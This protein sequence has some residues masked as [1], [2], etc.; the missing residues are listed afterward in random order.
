M[1]AEGSV[2]MIVNE[3]RKRKSDFE[4]R[5]FNYFVFSQ[6]WNRVQILPLNERDFI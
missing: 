3:I 5:F 1:S 2:T 4:G 6:R